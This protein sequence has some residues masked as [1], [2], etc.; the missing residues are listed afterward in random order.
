MHTFCQN[1]LQ[2]Y[3]STKAKQEE[4]LTY[5]ACPICRKPSCP[6]SQNQ[7]TSV[8]ATLF[9]LNT[10]LQSIMKGNK[11][12]LD[13]PCDICNAGGTM[14]T[15]QGLCTTC[16]ER[17]CDDC[18]SLHRRQKV[19]RNHAIITGDEFVGNPQCIMKFA[20][21]FNCPDHNTE[22]IKFYCVDHGIS[23]CGM[24][25]ILNHR[26]CDHVSDLK[27]ALPSLLKE[28]DPG[29]IMNRFNKLQIHVETLAEANKSNV[30]LLESQVK[31]IANSIRELRTELNS[32]LDEV[33]KRVQ[34]EGDK[35]YK[36][37]MIRTQEENKKCQSLISA[38]RN[39]HT[40]ME[41]VKQYG[42]DT[43]IFIMAEKMRAQITSYYD[44]IREKYGQT[45]FISLQLNITKRFSALLSLPHDALA[46]LVAMKEKTCLDLTELKW[47]VSKLLFQK[48]ET[49]K[50][51]YAHE[52]VPRYS[53]A[54]YLPSGQVMLA[55]SGDN[56]QVCLLDSSCSYKTSYTISER[57]WNICAIGEDEV[58]VNAPWEH[59]ILLL[60]VKE[61][62]ITFTR[63]IR[64]KYECPGLACTRNGD[65]IV[66]GSTDY[67]SAYWSIISVQGK[68]MSYHRFPYNVLTNCFIAVDSSN[69]CVYIAVES[70]LFC[71]DLK[72]KERFMYSSEDIKNPCGVALDCQDNVYVVGN[73]S[74]NIHQLSSDGCLMRNISITTKNPFS[75]C[76]SSTGNQCIIT[77][78]ESDQLH[79]YN[80]W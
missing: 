31:D 36:E 60:S 11:V 64:T 74:Q 45:E 71:S 47:P 40:L 44:E 4:E 39:S 43:Q 21:G 41:A 68:E 52:N 76:F 16:N 24:C 34:M 72:G 62:T 17:M 13:P 67:E 63:S 29:E 38:I 56:S 49:L 35:L 5:I 23:C 80:L 9:P 27:K 53:S 69:T 66:C 50:L 54:I 33:E 78:S 14:R 25:C 7:P 42:N 3:I 30:S 22:E 59:I 65:L 70:G 75:I 79:V 26:N 19:S 12:R 20:E 18:L 46:K 15:A 10:I 1:C 51:K 37:E 55:D 2:D 6:S 58:A 61:D 8:W 28:I 32:V 73:Q 48:T 77:S 57:P